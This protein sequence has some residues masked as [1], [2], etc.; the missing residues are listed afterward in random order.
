MLKPGQ[1]LCE[2][3]FNVA[4][5]KIPEKTSLSPY[6]SVVAFPNLHLQ[7]AKR[8]VTRADLLREQSLREWV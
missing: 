1:L 8:D 4:E 2:G 3:L 6:F 5:M 7:A